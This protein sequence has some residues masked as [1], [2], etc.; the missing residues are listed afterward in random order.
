M[1]ED[2]QGIVVSTILTPIREHS[3]FRAGVG[4][5][6]FGVGHDAIWKY[7]CEVTD[8]VSFDVNVAL[9]EPIGCCGGLVC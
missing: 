3:V 2:F 7:V 6:D 4:W 1:C 9:F 5:I 8:P